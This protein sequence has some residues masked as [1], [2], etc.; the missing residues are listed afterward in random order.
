M[1]TTALLRLLWSIAKPVLDLIPD[2]SLNT[3]DLTTSW[4]QYIRFVMWFLPTETISRIFSL[5]LMYWILRIALAF[6]RS[7]WDSLPIL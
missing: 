2:I 3:E 1:V 4:L 6:L 7:L 5:I